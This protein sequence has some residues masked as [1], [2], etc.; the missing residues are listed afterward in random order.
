MTAPSAARKRKSPRQSA[1]AASSAAEQRTD[2]GGEPGEHGEPAVEPDQRTA[3]VQIA[4]GSLGDHD[5]DAAGEALHEAREDQ[6]LDARAQRAHQRGHD[7]RDQRRSAAACRRPK[8]SESGPAISCPS[9][10]PIR[11]AVTVSCATE[12]AASSSSVSAGQHRQVQVHRDRAEHGQQEQHAG[13][14]RG[15]PELEVSPGASVTGEGADGCMSRHPANR[16]SSQRREF[17][18]KR[19]TGR[20]SLA[21]AAAPTSVGMDNRAEVREFLMSRRAKLTPDAAGLPARAE[22]ARRRAAPHRGRH[23]W[24]E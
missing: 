8:R 7:V 3:G 12:V 20:A 11:Q 23:R 16:F 10:R 1:M 24:R 9:A 5:P 4:P 18:M 14:N 21:D 22:P 2:D 15:M 6:H 19:C 13:R 17:L